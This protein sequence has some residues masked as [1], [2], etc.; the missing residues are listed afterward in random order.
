MTHR[1]RLRNVGRAVSI[2]LTLV[3]GSTPIG[4]RT[5]PPDTPPDCA[6]SDQFAAGRIE[7]SSLTGSY[8]ASGT[9]RYFEGEEYE[10]TFTVRSDLTIALV[11]GPSANFLDIA[12][13]GTVSGQGKDR[14]SGTIDREPLV[15]GMTCPGGIQ[16]GSPTIDGTGNASWN[17]V[18]ERMYSISGQVTGTGELELELSIDSATLEFLSDSRFSENNDCEW[19]EWTAGISGLD[20]SRSTPD[21]ERLRLSDTSY[22]PS[23]GAAWNPEVEVLDPVPWLERVGKLF[24]L[25]AYYDY[26]PGAGV[27][28]SPQLL[29]QAAYDG[30][31]PFDLSLYNAFFFL[32]GVSVSLDGSME[33]DAKEPVVTDMSLD[34]PSAFLEGV[35]VDTSVTVT[36]DWRD[37][38]APHQV[39][40]TY[41]GTVETVPAGGDETTWTFDA[42]ESAISIR[43]RAVSASG[44]SQAWEVATPKVALPEWA[45][46]T[47]DWSGSAGVRYEA[48]LDWPISLATTQSIDSL[49]LVSGLWG[50]EGSAMSEYGAAAR[51]SGAPSS[52]TFDTSASLRL[53]GRGFQFEMQGGTST[54]LS[55]GELTT[56]GNADA[57]LT[58]L[59]WE[60]TIHPVTAIPGLS[61]AVCGL[62]G[63]LCDLVESLGPEGEVTLDL[64]GSGQ[65]SDDG[66]D[67]TWNGGTLTGVLDA[68]ITA[69][70]IPRFA[71]G[72]VD[73]G[74]EGGGSGCLDFSFE[75]DFLLDRVGGEIHVGAFASFLGLSVAPSHDWPFGGGCA[76]SGVDSRGA[77]R[78]D[79]AGFVPA[80]GNLAMALSDTW[81]AAVWSA[82]PAGAERPAGNLMLRLWDGTA[83]EPIVALTDGSDAHSAPSAEFDTAGRLLVVHQHSAATPPTHAVDFDAYADTLELHSTMIDPA[84]ATILDT[85][86]LT[87]N[88]TSDFGASLVRDALGGVHLFWVRGDG[89][90]LFGTGAPLE[91]LTRSWDAVLGSWSAEEVVA[92]GLTGVLGWSAAAGSGGDRFVAL[93]VDLDLDLGGADDREVFSIER[94][95]G[96]G[97]QTPV[98]V[99]NDSVADTAPLAGFEASG[100]VVLWQREGA[101]WQVRGGVASEALAADPAAPGGALGTRLADGLLVASEEG[102]LALWP[103]SARLVSLREEADTMG[104][105]VWTLPTPWSPADVAQTVHAARVS[106]ND[107]VVGRA[108]R[109]FSPGGGGLE[110]SLLPLFE[111]R[112]WLEDVFEDGFESGDVTA[113]NGSTVE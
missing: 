113:W 95:D 96:L 75:P 111:R 66:S 48:T 12:C 18:I 78:R 79:P 40:F 68:R 98:R 30:L 6:V 64:A 52:G 1:S 82:V 53:A 56:Q 25:G 37:A 19:R 5:C 14:I 84:T 32:Q 58:G 59:R 31:D 107:W 89:A 26:G 90:D 13:D 35:P 102:L 42:S 57:T 7:F 28:S 94:L 36:V 29:T 17:V 70:P 55:C 92:S 21:V 3:V 71:R 65:F 112:V 45:G 72:I 16:V 22:D 60:K 81:G 76:R 104:G 97:W 100:P 23:D 87:D 108:D 46:D 86:V 109:A 62:S 20:L 15:A 8:D 91:L 67:I 101:V 39:E 73:L 9:E 10:D 51:S 38:D 74:I 88:A 105:S 4:A 54:T 85:D 49:P 47:G 110:D 93:L 43:A 83:W 103:E 24:Q 106:G 44:E 11:G 34:E 99:T 50:I 2:V 27:F 61:A 77:G 63:L 33:A 69:S 41:G 80:D